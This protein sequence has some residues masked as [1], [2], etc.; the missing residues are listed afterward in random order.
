MNKLFVAVG[1]MVAMLLASAG[2]IFADGLLAGGSDQA[3]VT[4][5]TLPDVFGF[6][7]TREGDRFQVRTT[8]PDGLSSLYTGWITTDGVL[9][10]ESLIQPESDDWY[11]AD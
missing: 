6:Y 4:A 7:I 2:P 11:H 10:D 9:S 8:D 1:G 5:D 3:V